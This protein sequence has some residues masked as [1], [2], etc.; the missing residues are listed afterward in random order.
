MATETFVQPAIPRFD[1]HYDHWSMLMENF[2][3]SKEYWQIVSEGIPESSGSTTAEAQKID[4]KA[5][6]Y[7]FQAIDRTILETILCKDT[8]K[9]IWDSMKKKYEGSKRVQRQQLQALRSEFETLR[10]KSGESVSDFSRTMSIVNKMLISG[11]KMEDVIVVEKI[12]RSMTPKFN[13]VVCSIEESKNIDLL[14]LD[15]LQASLLVH[16]KKITQQDKEEQAL[17]ASSNIYKKGDKS[18]VECYRCHKYGH[19][20]NEC[21]TN[22]T[23]DSGEKSNFAETEEEISLLMVCNTKE[24]MK[25]Q[26]WYLD[27]GCSNHMCGD[28]EIFSHLD[29]SYK[30]NV[31]FGNNTKISVMGKGEVMI[32]TRGNNYQI[33]YNV[34]FVPD[35]KTNLLSI[36]QLQEKEICESCVISKQSRTPFPKGKTQRA[37]ELLQ[38]VHSDLCGPINPI[39]NGGKRYIMTFIDDLS[40]KTWAYFLQEKSEALTA[41]KVFKAVVEKE[42]GCPIQVL[43]TDRGGEYNSH[44]FADFCELHGIKRQLTAAYTPQQ[45]GVCERKNRT[46]MNMVKNAFFLV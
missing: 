5:K 37:R 46:I 22:L 43:R 7:L 23:K 14:S 15:E 24:D 33:I 31:K 35:L 34:L 12:L 10:M 6:N 18:N 25:K 4:L 9:Q 45:N 20:Q 1:G 3:R 40:R 27:T 28:K 32:R 44:E 39:S 36:G 16:E 21:R 41:F 19:Y 30:D 11:E 38:I 8:S 42:A 17:L 29:E 26:L 2:L 13:Y